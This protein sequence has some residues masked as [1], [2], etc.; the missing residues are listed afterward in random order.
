[1]NINRIVYDVY[2]EWLSRAKIQVYPIIKL[3][4]YYYTFI[5]DNSTAIF[6]DNHFEKSK[7]VRIF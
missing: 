2:R 6:L 3:L 5:D 1:M 4:F 7:K